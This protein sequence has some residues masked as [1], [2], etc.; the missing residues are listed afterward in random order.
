MVTT[1]IAGVRA[2]AK[3]EAGA[4]LAATIEQTLLKGIPL[5]VNFAVKQVPGLAGLPTAVVK[6]LQ[7]VS[8]KLEAKLTL[9]FKNLRTTLAATFKPPAGLIGQVHEFDV[10]GVTHTI[11]LAK[12]PDK[13]LRVMLDGI[14]DAA[15]LDLKKDLP[16][17]LSAGMREKVRAA[18][19]LV[20]THGETLQTMLRVKPPKLKE[21]KALQSAAGDLGLA[22]AKLAEA[23]VGAPCNRLLA[24]C[25]C[26]GTLLRTKG[27]LQAIET[28][29]P[30]QLVLSRDEHDP[31]SANGY[32][33]VEE[34]FERLGWVWHLTAAGRLIRTTGEHPFH[35]ATKG[36]VACQEL[37]EGDR[38][39]CEDGSTIL[40]EEVV[41]TGEVEV[42]Y[43]LRVADWHT[44]FVGG[45]DWGFSVWAHNTYLVP[46]TASSGLTYLEIRPDDRIGDSSGQYVS[47]DWQ[48][49]VKTHGT[50]RSFAT[51]AEAAAAASR[52]NTL[53]MAL[54]E[55]LK[56]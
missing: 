46:Y 8:T 53:W 24:A 33:V 40:V 28:F 32:K 44:Y 10:E 21:A 45:E 13:T 22:I 6:G 30:G 38:L 55:A 49:S 47:A 52:I 20:L 37:S 56:E 11:W 51:P 26:H 23:L 29:E 7:S 16:E 14:G 9:M 5:A 2:V 42:V 43:N 19:A 34:V 35:E 50:A 3:G 15:K 18:V 17:N 25:F 41:D 48:D 1:A 12:Q 36:W 4:N 39:V 31:S 27:G 54:T